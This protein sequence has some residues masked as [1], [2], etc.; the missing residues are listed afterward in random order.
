M[1]LMRA[2]EADERN[3][4]AWLWLAGVMDDPED[5]RV[6]L[7]NVLEL[8]P[9]N[10]RA[11]QGLAWVEARYGQRASPAQ[12]ETARPRA[13][14]EPPRPPQ[15]GRGDE[16]QQQASMRMQHEPDSAPP[17]SNNPSTGT[18]AHL[19]EPSTAALTQQPA[20][21]PRTA[22]MPSAPA[23][24]S[25]PCPYCGAPTGPEQ[26]RCPSCRNNLMVRAAPDSSKRSAPLIILAILWALPAIITLA[27]MGVFMIGAALRGGGFGGIAIAPLI[28]GLV[29][30]LFVPSL[31]IARGLFLR[32]RW[33]YIAASI[34]A[35]L[36]TFNAV[37]SSIS[38]LSAARD[39][40]ILLEDPRITPEIAGFV[41]AFASIITFAVL[42]YQLL[43]IVL[44]TLG[45]PAVFGGQARFVHQIE[46]AADSK[47]HY[48]NGVA[49]KNRGMW[50]AATREW[51]QA[52]QMAPRDLQYLHALGLAYAQIKRFDKAR[53]ALDKAIQIAPD[54]E[55]LRESRALV[56]QME[57]QA[58]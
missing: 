29:L 7:E 24:A 26:R 45:Y 11:K 3:P 13:T 40:R 38:L 27:L 30:L 25:L 58:A 50:F 5:I 6:C 31:L 23:T 46:T 41:L 36:G 39:P 54:N 21:P 9:A 4:Q 34:F 35:V 18:T 47:I 43:V 42:G 22:S 53:A 19:H 15:N 32:R 57:R 1:L 2:V 51:E 12:Q 10:E 14:I 48:N 44:L 16:Q 49:L 17:A 52:A 8:D 56:D 33:A 37:T 20:A 55:Q 28:F